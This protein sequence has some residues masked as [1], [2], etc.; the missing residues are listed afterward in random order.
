MTN[1]DITVWGQKTV[2]SLGHVIKLVER[3]TKNIIIN[4]SSTYIE[5]WPNVGCDECRLLVAYC[6]PD[7][8]EGGCC[9]CGRTKEDLERLEQEYYDSI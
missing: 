3:I 7:D 2:D 4:R 6:P 9:V 5:H 1:K 8:Y